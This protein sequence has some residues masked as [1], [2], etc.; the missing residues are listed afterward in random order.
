MWLLDRN[1]GEAQ[2][3]TDVKGRL[4]SYEWS[5]DG[6]KLLLVMADRDPNDAAMTN[7]PAAG[8]GGPGAKAPKPIVI[9]R[10]KFK[11][12]V[13]GIP[14]AAADATVSVR[15]GEQEGRGADRGGAGSGR[16]V[17]V[18]GREVDCV[19]WGARARM[20]SGTTRGNVFVMEA[21]AGAA[22]RQMTQYDGVRGSA[23]ADVRSGVRTARGWS[24]LQIS[25]A[26]QSAYNMT[27]LAVVAVSGGAAEDS[28]GEARSRSFRAAVYAG[29]SIDSLPGGATMRPNIPRDCRPAAARCSG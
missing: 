29:R 28:G 7:A 24:Y 5:P 10:Y 20:R 4:T 15:C 6:K 14:D 19:H 18:A 21:R 25:G 22:P 1:G 17:V 16:A 11:Q 13:V 27:R 3:F 26:K 8:A 12:D 2:Q 9:D 23:R